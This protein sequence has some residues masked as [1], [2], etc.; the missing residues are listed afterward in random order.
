MDDPQ[1]Y[2]PHKGSGLTVTPLKRMLSVPDLHA[3]VR[4]K[5]L[6]Y[7]EEKYAGRYGTPR[8]RQQGFNQRLGGR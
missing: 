1:G 2:S 6:E 5:V 3:L 8:N 7:I 4:R